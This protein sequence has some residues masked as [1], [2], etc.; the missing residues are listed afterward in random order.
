MTDDNANDETRPVV[1][2][3]AL[4][5]P[6]PLTPPSA[7]ERATG[8]VPVQR[9]VG[10]T[11]ADGGAP[12]ADETPMQQATIVTD[13]PPAVAEAQ[14]ADEAVATDNRPEELVEATDAPSGESTP[15]EEPPALVM[16]SS[17]YARDAFPSQT[18]AD[19]ANDSGV[20]DP[21]PTRDDEQLPDDARG[22]V[23][24]ER[25]PDADPVVDGPSAPASEGVREEPVEEAA[26]VEERAVEG[27]RTFAE[28][29]E[30]VGAP[31]Q[32]QLSEASAGQAPPPL[33][34][35]EPEAPTRTINAAELGTGAIV[36]GAETRTAPTAAPAPEQ[37][38]PEQQARA[39]WAPEQR[40]PE[41]RPSPDAADSTDTG[42]S[43]IT[44]VPPRPAASAA[45]AGVTTGLPPVPGA[46]MYEGAEEEDDRT[47]QKPRKK[48]NRAL[49]FLLALLGTVVFAAAWAGAAY[50]ILLFL[51]QTGEWLPFLSTVVFLV[52]IAIYFVATLLV[53]LLANRAGA[54]AHVLGSLLIGALVYFGMIALY[55][56]LDIGGRTEPVGSLER[57]LAF[58]PNV[59]FVV[60]ALLAREVA[61]WSGI[62]LAARGRRLKAQN[63]EAR[64][65]YERALQAH[66]DSFA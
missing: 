5:Q 4:G 26:P 9:D 11:D 56:F 49:G 15:V 21:V 34:E 42:V 63:A 2:P 6:A 3:H 38:T 64:A 19:D 61:L 20:V 27:D 54:W 45:S 53:K 36:A 16:S 50:L 59:Y 10:E 25:R 28:D 37:R 30:S 29:R 23:E 31:V 22:V 46:E 47:P 8:S 18:D 51:G 13:E 1:P 66:D 44:E 52:P 55:T 48:G 43:P 32:T 57:L 17:T 35:P 40:T 39:Q 12:I 14:P 62:A 65:E 41:Q 24:Q 58:V 7:G 33:V 60:A